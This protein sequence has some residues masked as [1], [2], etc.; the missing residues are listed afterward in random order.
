MKNDR[1]TWED[2][3]FEN[4]NK[5]YGAYELRTTAGYNLLKSLLVVIFMIGV[6]IMAFSKISK[7]EPIVDKGNIP[8]IIILDNLD[9][10]KPPKPP[11]KVEIAV[12]PQIT[13]KDKSG[14]D[15]VPNPISNP[16]TESP[17][18]NQVDL[19]IAE[20]PENSGDLNDIGA[21]NPTTNQANGNTENN[22]NSQLSTSE[23]PKT[24]NP[25]QV[26]KMAVF[27]GC[28]NSKNNDELNNCMASK[29]S[30]ELQFQLKDFEEVAY[31]NGITDASARL[32]FVVDR[33][34]RIVQIQAVKTGNKEL[35]AEA[36]KALNRVSQ[37]L[38]KKGKF[39]KPAEANDGTP[40]NLIFNL[41]IK[42]NTK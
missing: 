25:R 14:T 11:E 27:P 4:R 5:A 15:I 12:K 6:A 23:T 16:D 35:S 40:V 39:I 2:F 37:K 9:D 22:T 36:Q 34:G 3:L 17:L 10:F 19:G 32:S 13:I 41:P 30:E 24:M 29:L 33:N 20:G 7:G 1:Q 28:E 8:P 21:Y 38:I 42:Y 26:T 18:A 31:Q